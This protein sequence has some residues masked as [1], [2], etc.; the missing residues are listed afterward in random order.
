[1]EGLG[2]RPEEPEQGSGEDWPLLVNTR[3]GRRMVQSHG[4]TLEA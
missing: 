2:R 1:M 3:I 4:S